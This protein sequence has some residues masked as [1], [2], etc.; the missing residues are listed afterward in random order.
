MGRE[1]GVFKLSFTQ[2][3]NDNST[4]WSAIWSEIIR[5]ISKSNER[6]ARVRFEITGIYDFRPKLQDTKFNYHFITSILKSQNL[7][8]TNI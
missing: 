8:S 1:E 2:P 7:V 5:V 4:E 3:H 6:A